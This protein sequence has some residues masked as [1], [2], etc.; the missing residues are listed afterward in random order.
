MV[1]GPIRNISNNAGGSRDTLNR[2]VK[3]ARSRGDVGVENFAGYADE[4]GNE[5]YR[6]VVDT[7]ALPA[8][9]ASPVAHGIVG[10]AR[11]LVLRGVA[12]DD[13]AGFVKAKA[14]GDAAFCDLDMDDT[15]VTLTTIAD[16]TAY[17]SSQVVIEYTKA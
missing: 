4:L 3:L 11:V 15:N 16:Q 12:S 1:I 10:I 9:A 5:V 6:M 13:S 7:G 14:L 2:L 17:D 8:T